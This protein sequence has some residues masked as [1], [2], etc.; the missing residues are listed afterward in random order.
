[1]LAAQEVN[2]LR[3]LHTANNMVELKGGAFGQVVEYCRSTRYSVCKPVV[4]L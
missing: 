4:K 1:M 3:S 2:S